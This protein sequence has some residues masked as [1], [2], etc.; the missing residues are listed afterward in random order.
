MNSPFF[1]L[2]I[3]FYKVKLSM[4]E[5]YISANLNHL[6]KKIHQNLRLEILTKHDKS[7]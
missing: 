1:E 3:K 6:S 5:K 4:S 7:I 2:K